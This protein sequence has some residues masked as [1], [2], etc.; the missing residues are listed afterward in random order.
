MLLVVATS[1]PPLKIDREAGDPLEFMV[2]FSLVWDSDIK[3]GELPEG[4]GM[5]HHF[6]SWTKEGL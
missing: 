1:L 4:R 6:A 3:L 5:L 2:T